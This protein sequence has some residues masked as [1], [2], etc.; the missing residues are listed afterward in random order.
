[1]KTGA[2][3]ED[4]REGE[5]ER[6]ELEKKPN[7]ASGDSMKISDGSENSGFFRLFRKIIGV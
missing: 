2:G 3:K 6:Q 5:T 1:M 7:V 4:E